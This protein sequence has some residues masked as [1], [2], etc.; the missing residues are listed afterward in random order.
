MKKLLLIFSFFGIFIA[1]SAQIEDGEYNPWKYMREELV[2]SRLEMLKTM[3]RLDCEKVKE[4]ITHLDALRKDKL[5][6]DSLIVDAY[7]SLRNISFFQC[8]ESYNYLKHLIKT[9]TS[10]H[11]RCYAITLLGWMR[12]TESIAFLKELL[13]KEGLTKDERYNAVLAYCQIAIASERQDLMDE[14]DRLV[15]EF[16]GNKNGT[17]YN[18]LDE[19]CTTLY[20]TIGGAPAIDYFSYCLENETNSLIAALKLAQLGEYEKTYPVFVEVLKNEDIDNI[21]SALQGLAAIGTPETFELIRA[22]TQNE[23][24]FIAKQAQYIFEY[25]DRKRREQ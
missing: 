17:A 19:D 11:F 6:E 1:L 5:E 22:Q 18:C 23:N 2:L 15:D 20:F 21:F 10:E 16:C 25:I 14:S 4:E 3:D 24:S 7:F 8:S 12:N 9:D 13:K